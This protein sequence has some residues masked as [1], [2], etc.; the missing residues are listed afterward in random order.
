V[1]NAIYL[2]LNCAG[3]HRGYGVNISYVRS[4]TMDSWND[5]NVSII[6][7]GGNRK[8]NELLGLYHI[9]KKKLNV[10]LYNTKILDFYRRLIKCEINGEPLPQAISRND[11][12]KLVQEETNVKKF[13]EILPGNIDLS[14]TL[15]NINY[16]DNYKSSSSNNSSNNNSYSNIDRFGSGIDIN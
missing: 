15:Q 2:C 13:E 7:K 9:N 14:N 8:L 5:N 11:A 12:L 16:K 3:E 4:I 6:S 1:N 10:N